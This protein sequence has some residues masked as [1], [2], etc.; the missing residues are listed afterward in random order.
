MQYQCTC[1]C[2]SHSNAIHE[3][4]N[5]ETFCFWDNDSFAIKTYHK[6]EY[7]DN[8]QILFAVVCLCMYNISHNQN[9]QCLEMILYNNQI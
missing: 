3:Y 2:Y 4:K 5:W 9:L 1:H 6:I 7:V 8:L